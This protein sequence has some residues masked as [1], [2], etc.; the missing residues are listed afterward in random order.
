MGKG[1][2]FGKQD[3]NI[4]LT[5]LNVLGLGSD[6][7]LNSP[8]Q[9]GLRKSLSGKKGTYIIFFFSSPTNRRPITITI[10]IDLIV[11]LFMFIEGQGVTGVVKRKR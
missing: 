9:M 4:S 11:K 8:S 3:I 7:T 5:F 2:D 10:T 1:F 6:T